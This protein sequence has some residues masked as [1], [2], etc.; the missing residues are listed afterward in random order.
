MNN[1]SYFLSTLIA[2]LFVE[3]FIILLLNSLFDKSKLLP[4]LIEVYLDRVVRLEVGTGVCERPKPISPLLYLCEYE[5]VNYAFT[6]SYFC[7]FILSNPILLII[8][9]Y[10]NL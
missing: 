1:Y 5:F 8:I 7:Y 9:F 2:S 3:Q 4:L 6:V 10:L